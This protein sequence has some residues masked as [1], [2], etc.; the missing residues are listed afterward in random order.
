MKKIL[1]ISFLLLIVVITKAQQGVAINTDA[2]LPDNSAILDIKS[3][4]K[5][6]LIPRMT[7]AQSNAIVNPATGLMIYRID[8]SAGFYFNSGTPALPNWQP[9][10]SN[11]GNGWGLT[12]NGGTNPATNFLG[13][14]DNQPLIIKL[15]NS[16]AGKW[17][18]VQ[19]SYFLGK[20][21]GSLNAGEGNIAFGDSSLHANSIGSGN[22]AIGNRALRKN[23]AGGLVA[24]GDG[25][26][27]NNIDGGYNVAV[28][29][30]A[31]FTNFSGTQNTAI[32]S[33]S[34]HFNT[35]FS[36][37]ATGT[38]ALHNNSIGNF[39]TAIGNLTM[40]SN[41]SGSDNTVVGDLA[42]YFN[43]SGKSLVA[44]GKNALRNNTTGHSNIAIGAGSLLHNKIHS[45]NVALGD[46]A[47]FKNG[48]NVLDLSGAIGNTGL[49]S[50]SLYSNINGS[51][52]TATGNHA[53]YNNITGHSNTAN[54]HSA[55]FFNSAGNLNT[56]I[57][58]GALNSNNGLSNTAIGADAGHM[59]EGNTKTTFLG[60]DSDN[61][62]YLNNYSNSTAIGFLSKITA[63]NQVRIGNAN[64][65]SIGGVVPWS[66]VSD[67]RFKM[68]MKE[69]V[70]GLD[71]IMKLRPV[72]YNLDLKKLNK[73]LN[74]PDSL[75]SKDQ[76][77]NEKIRHTGFVAQEVEEAAKQTGFDFSGVEKP[78]KDNGHYGLRYAEFVVPLVKAMQEQQ[79]Q[80]NDL[81]KQIEELKQLIQVKK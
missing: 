12:G 4:N 30:N 42:L 6:L 43:T 77:E 53:L 3:I 41:T 80:I 44:V 72:T 48:F 71:F 27:Y 79:Q 64:V 29:A 58:Y 25:A 50:K 76:L 10:V 14:T 22:T 52:N 15:N 59:A 1:L 66:V 16:Y 75:Q 78:G 54:G 37:T 73:Q 8:G 7:I 69:D 35:G 68:N 21:A 47:L 9:L 23:V 70:K 65:T 28:G 20:G 74:V 2:S 5:G 26:L 40:F 55:L 81:K 61:D 32:G 13:T 49:G 24:I 36:N 62:T 31:L 19:N 33:Y 11:T 60:A 17:D 38:Y 18:P 63:S 67:G 39:N 56:A 46:S 34:L 57:G 45:N 51:Y